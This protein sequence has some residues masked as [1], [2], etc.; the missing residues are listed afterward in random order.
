MKNVETTLRP[1][2][3]VLATAK[4][5]AASVIIPAIVFVVGVVLV[6]ISIPQSV[7]DWVSMLGYLVGIIGLWKLVSSVAMWRTTKLVLTD[8]RLL[9]EAGLFPHKS[10]S[11]ALNHVDRV[12]VRRGILGRLMGYGTLIVSA[13]GEGNLRVQYRQI[14]GAEELA[15]KI[16]TQMSVP[17]KRI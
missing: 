13:R 2:E 17:A 3:N 9:C 6:I 7:A 1:G 4:I 12:E 16:R 11:P 10:M 8:E 5:H 14:V 15:Q